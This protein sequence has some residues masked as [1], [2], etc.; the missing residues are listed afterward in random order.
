MKNLKMLTTLL[1]WV[2]FFFFSYKGNVLKNNE[3]IAGKSLKA[4][5]VLLINCHKYKLKR[6]ILCQLFDSSVGS[7]LNHASEICGF[8]KSKE[9][10]R[11]HLK[12]CKNVLEV[13]TST[14]K[15]A[16][17][18]ELGHYPLY[19]TRYVNIVKCWLK[20]NNTENIL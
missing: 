8:S 4:L 18:A 6:K 13:R 7:I 9:L 2:Q 20:S 11:I 3:L 12:F 19:I 1:I 16:V 15:A 14:S 10:E 17:Y 5:N